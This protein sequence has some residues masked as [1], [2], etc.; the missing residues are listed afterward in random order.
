MS[1]KMKTR[2]LI[3]IGMIGFVGVAF[4]EHDPNQLLEHS[5]ILPPDMKEK[6]FEEFM[7]WCEPYYGELCVKLE[8]NRIPTILSPLKQHEMG[9]RFQ[10]IQCRDGLEL[11]GKMPHAYPKC[12]KPESVE[13][14]VMRGWATTD[15]TVELANPIAYSVT[16]NNTD[17]EVLYSLKGATLESIVHDADANSVHVSLSESVG[18]YLVIS[19]PR[20]L[21]DAKIGNSEVD[22]VYFLLID[23]LEHMYGEKKTDDSR[24]ITVWFSK[25]TQDIEIIRTFWI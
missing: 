4:A 19:I 16:K 22:D 5:I 21:I 12:I 15:K 23:G 13:K 18:G 8:K 1:E 25:N 7:D 24:I 2:F 10:D 14:L 17:F 9:V 6:T 11:V 20:D 3:I